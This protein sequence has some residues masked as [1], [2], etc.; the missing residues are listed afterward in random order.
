MDSGNRET[1]LVV[2]DEPHVVTLVK[3]MLHQQGY[4]VLGA[5]D[6]E[7]AAQI[8]Q[9]HEPAIHLLLTDIA[10]PQL[11][12]RDLADRL[13]ALRRGMRVLYMSGFMEE[14]LLKYYGVSIAGIPFL[15]KP[16]TPETLAGKVREVLDAPAAGAAGLGGKMR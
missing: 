1:I 4:A 14:A 12:G 6:P 2:D 10:M 16:F 8:A 3:R 9:A 5:T 13:K 7:E 11:N 15:Q